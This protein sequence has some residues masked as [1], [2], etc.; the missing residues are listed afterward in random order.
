MPTIDQTYKKQNSFAE[1]THDGQLKDV[2]PRIQKLDKN[3]SSLMLSD[4]RKAIVKNACDE[5]LGRKVQ[6]NSNPLFKLY[7]Y[8]IEEIALLTDS[9][10][11]ALFI[12][13][14]PLRYISSAFEA[15]SL[16]TLPSN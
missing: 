11:P 13:S 12:L 9:E 5:L 14:L 10:L 8:N 3:L 2:L 16:S 4:Y 6:D 15:G 7:P 1:Q